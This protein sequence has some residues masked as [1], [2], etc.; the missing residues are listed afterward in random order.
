MGFHRDAL[1]VHF[2]CIVQSHDAQ[3]IALARKGFF[4][5]WKGIEVTGD[6]SWGGDLEAVRGGCSANCQAKAP[7][8]FMCT[9]SILPDFLSQRVLERRNMGGIPR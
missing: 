4:L 2:A 6:K 9:S 5:L 7:V 3:L 8:V 1:S